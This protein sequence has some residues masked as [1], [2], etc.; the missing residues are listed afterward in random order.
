MEIK[1]RKNDKYINGLLLCKSKNYDFNSWYSLEKS[2]TIKET[3]KTIKET[4]ELLKMPVSQ[5]VIFENNDNI[6]IH[7]DIAIHISY[8]ISSIFG[9]LVVNWIKNL[10]IKEYE[11][12]INKKDI[13]IKN[14]EEEID[15]FINIINDCINFFN[16]LTI[17]KQPIKDII[18]QSNNELEV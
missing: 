2:K 10:F 3:S 11:K 8:W 13:I 12:E 16:Q 1:I 7:P 5:L 9:L 17:I 15:F 18:G 4:S 6:W 14:K